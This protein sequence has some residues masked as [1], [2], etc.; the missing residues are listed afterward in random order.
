MRLGKKAVVAGVAAL[1]LA[2]SACGSGGSSGSG[3][4]GNGDGAG[5]GSTELLADYNP[6][7]RDKVKDGGTVT[8]PITEVSAQQ[9][10]FQADGS[11]YTNQLWTWYNPQMMFFSPEGEWSFNKDYLSDVKDEEKDGNTVITYTI[12]PKAK[13]NDGSPITWETF[14]TTW[15][16][17]N[18]KNSK[19][20]A[21]STDGYSQ[22]KSVTK[23]A[24]DKQ[25][26]VTFDGPWAWWQ[27]LFNLVLNPHVDNPDVY[28][29]GYLNKMHPEWGA[30]PYT[31]DNVDFK[32]GIVNFKQN[33]KWWGDKGKLDKLTFKQMEDTASINAFKN[34]EIDQTGVAT[35]DRLAQVKDMPDT[36]IHRATRLYVGVFELN[37]DRPVLKDAKVR[38]AI[39][40]GIDRQT[41]AKIRF[42]GLDYSEKPPG[43]L[44][45]LPFQDG[46]KDSF[47]EAGYKYDKA[48]AGK[49]LDEAGWTKGSDGI[50]EKDGKKLTFELPLTGD[51]PS[52]I[53]QGKAIV[54]MLKEIGVDMKIKQI[55]S[56]DFSNVFSGGDW[57]A[58]LLGFTQSDPFGVAYMCQLYCSSSTSLNKSA[59]ADKADDAKIEALW[60]ISDQK[61]QTEAGMK[62]EVEIMKKTWGIMPM[63][64]GPSISV[65]KKG[66]ANLTPEPY[67]G[68]DGF[69]IQPVQNFGWQK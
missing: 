6:Q 55:A 63:W 66:L 47:T 3:G 25:A 22:I 32:T 68:L 64:N 65:T 50:R 67:S 19:Y 39:M 42:N 27:G 37:A 4:D 45:L 59:T 17:N 18:G 49:M 12:N 15:E 46:Y 9:N 11:A 48:A 38:Q 44:N 28:N 14:K 43:S 7:P 20:I 21:S 2:L 69:G 23:G 60:K 40:E 26:V 8:L 1:A 13:W 10:T 16:T 30:G 62:L 36:T 41:V 34:G 33:P 35:K 51:D 24:D 29:K 58:F 5:Q 61:E 56:A 53:A 54:S 52:I 57:D 31:I